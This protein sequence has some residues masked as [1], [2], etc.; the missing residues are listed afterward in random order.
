MATEWEVS[1]G[2]YHPEH[3][4]KFADAQADK[5]NVFR[6]DGF[7]NVGRLTPESVKEIREQLD[8]APVTEVVAG[9]AHHYDID[10][11]LAI[12]QF[13]TIAFLPEVTRIAAIHI[14]AEPKILDVSCWKTLPGDGGREAAQR[15]HRDIDDWRACK[16][17]VYLTDVGPE[18]GPHLFV[19]ASHR[20]D[21]FE[22]RGVPAD[23]YFLNGGSNPDL[24]E[25]IESLPRFEVQAPA[26][27]MFL[28]NTYG[29]H[30]GKP[31]TAGERILFQV[32]Y[33]LMEVEKFTGGTKIPKIRAKWG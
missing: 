29:F 33:G 12:A 18:N 22:A 8:K 14:G 25:T 15:W 27:H 26:G 9:V 21:F 5:W 24:A 13:K 28:V 16:L 4:R 10:A 6:R 2:T 1:A 30:R 3:R 17:F 19:P 31:V 7:Q 32:C 11:V 23:A 20:Y